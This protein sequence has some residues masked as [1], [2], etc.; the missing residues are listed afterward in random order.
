MRKKTA[1]IHGGRAV[2]EATGALSLPIVQAS[3]FR[4]RSIGDFEYEYARTGNP[5]R[6]GVELLIA[7]LEQGD[8]GFAF[9]SGM[10][11]ITAVMDL[12]EAGDHL[13]L[14]EDVY[15]GTY[16]LMTQILSRHQ[17]DIT[18]VDTTNK[19]E[20]ERAIQENTKA[21]F[22]ETPT[23]PLL[24][25]TS[26]PTI[27]EIAKKANLL[28]IV[29]NTFSTPYFQNPIEHGADIVVHSA[30]K[31][32]GGH[33]DVVAGLVVTKGRALGERLHYIQNATGGVLAPHDSWLLIRGMKTLGV[34]MEEIERSAQKIAQYLH[35]HERV[36]KV[37]YPGFSTHPGHL[38][39]QAQASGYGG[40]ISF[41]VKGEEEAKAVVENVRYFTL[42][43]SLGAVESLISVPAKMTHASIPKERRH[44]IGIADGLVRLSVGLEDAEDLLEDLAHALQFA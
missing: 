10:A 21:I 18:F 26:L 43:E 17:I 16:R 15:G 33:S 1:L 29:D 23:N 7:E 36:E 5:T 3:T 25:I 20:V 9:A 37:Y 24:K 41:V 31:Y 6:E 30:T 34:R 28:L 27:A 8:R 32:L 13:L 12:F 11:A 42:A 44:E 35:H 14:S 38:T 22:I 39:H 40:M 2:D 19:E 4:Q